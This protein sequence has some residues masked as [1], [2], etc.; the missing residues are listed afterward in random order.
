MTATFT[1]QD[2]ERVQSYLF[3]HLRMEMNSQRVTFGSIQRIFF[4]G[5]SQYRGD[6]NDGTARGSAP[7]VADSQDGRSV[8]P[9]VMAVPV[10][11][12]VGLGLFAFFTRRRRRQRQDKQEF[13]VDEAILEDA[14]HDR[15]VASASSLVPL[16]D[17]Q[18]LDPPPPLLLSSCSESSSSM[19]E[20][21]TPM[22]QAASADLEAGH[23]TPRTDTAL[24]EGEPRAD[25]PNL[26]LDLNADHPI[27][28]A[29]TA[30]TST[31]ATTLPQPAAPVVVML[32]NL[33]PL[34]PRGRT[35][36]KGSLQ[37]PQSKTL[38]PKRRRKKKKKKAPL[39]RVNSRENIKEMETIQEA[40]LEYGSDEDSYEYGSGSEYSWST[41]ETDSRPGS[42]DPSPIR[43]H[44][45]SP[46]R[47]VYS[48]G[49]LA[50]GQFSV[51]TSAVT[52]PVSNTATTET[53]PSSM[54]SPIQ[55]EPKIRPL[56][57]P[58]V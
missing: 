45:K 33:P 54:P 12:A 46:S 41:D 1:G 9:I 23:E 2:E 43:S 8:L 55:E 32:D 40:S 35:S 11:V 49:S 34:P 58:W 19:D 39:K 52:E 44:S 37:K 20:V 16:P 27:H 14:S 53:K 6:P 50:L 21:S 38:K 42:R 17:D 7:G 24:D 3:Y 47:S 56:P 25:S 5:P 10:A 36:S 4:I 26:L 22:S 15:S 13:P 31:A 48:Q 30:T 29:P 18:K 57:P 28:H 51:A